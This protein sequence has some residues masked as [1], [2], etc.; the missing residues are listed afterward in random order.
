[1]RGLYEVF[2]AGSLF[3]RLIT[4]AIV[5]YCVLSWY[6]PTFRAFEMLR[7]FI[8]PFLKPFR[9]LAMW[10]ASY[11]R[12]PLDFTCLFAVLGYEILERVW[13]RLYMLLARAL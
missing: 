3:L 13:W 2:Y 6:R 4:T 1:M 9:R 10:V 5:I 7:A 8:E 12:A 11:F